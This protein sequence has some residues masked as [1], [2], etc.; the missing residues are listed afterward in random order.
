MELISLF[1]QSLPVG[2]SDDYDVTSVH[3]SQFCTIVSVYAPTLQADPA[4]K[5]VFNNLKALLGCADK[6]L[7][8]SDFQCLSW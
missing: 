7:I 8:F 2:H 4:T 1:K 3:N 6:L 5:E